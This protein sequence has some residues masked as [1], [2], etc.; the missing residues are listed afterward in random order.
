MA[1]KPVNRGERNPR[2][3]RNNRANLN[4]NNDTY[5]KARGMIR[6]RA[7]EIRHPPHGRT[8]IDKG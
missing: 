4:P 3:N 1:R 6:S 7:T 5:W 2:G 8:R